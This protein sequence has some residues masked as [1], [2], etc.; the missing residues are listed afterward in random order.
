MRRGFSTF[1]PGLLLQNA[2]TAKILVDC[3][4]NRLQKPAPLMLL[5]CY[6][7]LPRCY[8]GA[9]LLTAD[10]LTYYSV[11]TTRSNEAGGRMWV[12]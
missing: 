6:L 1:W 5:E 3:S 9:P 2:Q 12:K 11:V 8:P 7:L 10:T 4:E